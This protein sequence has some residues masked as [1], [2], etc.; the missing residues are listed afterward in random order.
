VTR[1][2]ATI[3]IGR[4][5]EEVFAYVSDPLNFPRWN[6]AVQSI[7]KTAGAERKVGSTYQMERRLR[8]G[9]VFNELE[10]FTREHPTE[11]GIRTTS[12]RTPFSYHCLFSGSHGETVVQL[13]AVVE[14]EAARYCWVPSSGARSSPE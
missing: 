12:G 7:R 6:S 10:I 14:L 8:G 5:I 11:F 9:R 3:H 1:F 13:D 2:K 4:P